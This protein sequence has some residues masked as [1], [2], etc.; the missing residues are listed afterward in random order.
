MK[1]A[2]WDRIKHPPLMKRYFVT[3]PRRAGRLL[4]ATLLVSGA[5]AL[6]PAARVAY[7]DDGGDVPRETGTEERVEH[8][9][10]RVDPV[11]VATVEAAEDVEHEAA[12]DVELTAAKPSSSRA[13]KRSSAKRRGSAPKTAKAASPREEAKEQAAAAQP[14]VEIPRVA[15]P[16]VPDVDARA[17]DPASCRRVLDEYQLAY[18]VTEGASPENFYVRP[19]GPIGGVVYVFDGRREVH[20]VMDCR[21]V[22]ALLKWAP[23]LR[24]AGVRKIRHLSV[25]R[26]DARIAASGKPSGHALALAIDVRFVELED[27]RIL[28]VLTDWGNRA[29]GVMPCDEGVGESDPQPELRRLTCEVVG[30]QLFQTVITPHRDELHENHVH[31]ELVPDVEWTFVR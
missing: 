16:T 13:R 12:E 6:R 15:P 2:G 1:R 8:L 24:N 17:L 19:K 4:I 20:E 27:G 11:D 3:S 9:D 30:E 7:S 25:Y 5:C 18:D 28:D 31:L 26:P 23:S 22:V 29:R 10:D 14:P 21:L